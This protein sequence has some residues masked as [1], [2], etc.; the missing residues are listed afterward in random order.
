MLASCQCVFTQTTHKTCPVD[1]PVP[2]QLNM[3]AVLLC[4]CTRSRAWPNGWNGSKSNSH[5]AVRFHSPPL[6]PTNRIVREIK[7]QERK[8]RG[9]KRKIKCDPT[10]DSTHTHTHTH[11]IRNIHSTHTQESIT[12][13]GDFRCRLLLLRREW[14]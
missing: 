3:R 9:K 10:A 13:D 4:P 2:V 1:V 14:I 8:N 11:T 6:S 5:I 12:K 7:T